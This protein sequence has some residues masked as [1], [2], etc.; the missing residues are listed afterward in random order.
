VSLAAAIEF[1]TILRLRPLTYV[2]ADATAAIRSQGLFPVVGLLLGLILVGLDRGLSLVL[3]A[4][5]V[6]AVLAVSLALLTGGLHL[7]GLAD[8]ADGLFG[9]HTPEQRLAIMRDSR[10]GTYG[11]LAIACVLLLKWVALAS[12]VVL[13]RP[14]AILIFPALGRLAMVLAVAGFSY[15]RAHGLGAG[16]QEAARQPVTLVTAVAISIAA[17]VLLFSVAG[18]ALVAV[19]ALVAGLTG[20]YCRSRLGG[21]T[22]DTYGAV[23]ELTEVVV[24]FVILTGQETGWLIPLLWKG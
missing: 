17:A 7:D 19:A 21:L 11:A 3:P 14:G 22:G 16:W 23:S 18:L 20:L 10:T 15:G 12:L 4:A 9:G 24:L 6:A 2:R 8:T 1:L 5:A 13:Y